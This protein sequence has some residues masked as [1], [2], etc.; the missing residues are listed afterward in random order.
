MIN[1]DAVIKITAKNTCFIF[2]LKL[3]IL[4]LF[5]HYCAPLTYTQGLLGTPGHFQY[6][7]CFDLKY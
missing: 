6:A 7:I 4:D 3:N 1:G 2:N 5:G